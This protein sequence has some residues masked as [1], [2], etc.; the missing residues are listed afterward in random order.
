M[1]NLLLGALSHTVNLCLM[2]TIF[3][4]MTGVVSATTDTLSLRQ[5]TYNQAA[6]AYRDGNYQESYNLYLTIA[7]QGVVSADLFY[8]LGNACSQ[9]KKG[10]EAV[11]WYERARM[12]MPRDKDIRNNLRLV[13]PYEI[14]GEHMVLTKPLFKGLMYFSF[15]EWAIAFSV[16][17]ILS[18]V[19]FV[20]RCFISNTS[21]PM[22]TILWI[23]LSLTLLLGAALLYNYSSTIRQQF[24]IVSTPNTAMKSGPG[25]NFKNITVLPAGEKVQIKKFSDPQWN[26]ISLSNGSEGFIHRDSAIQIYPYTSN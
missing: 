6:L 9:L 14:D 10:G 11:L 1:K 20:M 12:L 24:A 22:K 8:N 4:S 17:I 25:E 5:N 3:Y 16:A 19:L 15:S 21:G 13:A 7:Q 23:S 18:G 2:L 26:H